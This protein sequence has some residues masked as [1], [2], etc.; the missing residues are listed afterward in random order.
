MAKVCKHNVTC[1]PPVRTLTAMPKGQLPKLAVEV[2]LLAAAL[3]P[4]CDQLAMVPCNIPR[5]SSRRLKPWYFKDLGIWDSCEAPTL[6]G[7]HV[8]FSVR[9]IIAVQ[10]YMT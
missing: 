4:H 2:F 7:Q 8:Q 9:R 5:E 10:I 1:Y 3:A 6:H